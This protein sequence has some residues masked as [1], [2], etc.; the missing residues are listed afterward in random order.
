MIARK[1]S[2]DGSMLSEPSE[3]SEASEPSV[4][5]GSN[6]I[7]CADSARNNAPLLCVCVC[8]CRGLRRRYC[9]A[10]R[11]LRARVRAAEVAAHR[12]AAAHEPHAA[13]ARRLADGRR[14]GV[15]GGA[16]RRAGSATGERRPGARAPAPARAAAGGQRLVALARAP[17]ASI[18]HRVSPRF[19]RRLA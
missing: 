15:R 6:W 4:R 18:H 1:P 12:R 13:A 5:G 7:L 2:S 8:D 3:P 9:P 19:F 10:E 16:G 11:A 14:P 17:E